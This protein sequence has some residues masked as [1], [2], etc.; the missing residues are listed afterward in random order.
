MNI[1][2]ILIM[3]LLFFCNFWASATS[4]LAVPWSCSRSAVCCA[5]LPL[6]STPSGRP[7]SRGPS[8]TC[9]GLILPGKPGGLRHT[10]CSGHS[11]SR[12]P[13]TAARPP[14][15]PPGS[16]RRRGGSW[17]CYQPR[18]WNER[19]FSSRPV[20]GVSTVVR[21][22][23]TKRRVPQRGEPGQKSVSRA[24]WNGAF[25]SPVS[26]SRRSLKPQGGPSRRRVFL[27]RG[28]QSQA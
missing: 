12:W 19:R 20:G 24:V 9:A 27:R 18:R 26:P 1:L 5:E 28:A 23:F 10:R 2:S 13:G 3:F 11:P 21:T 22:G 25:Y 17:P 14:A 16:G 8:I 6:K 7:R 4:R 15:K